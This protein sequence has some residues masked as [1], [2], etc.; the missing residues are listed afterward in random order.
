[1]GMFKPLLK[2]PLL[3]L[4]LMSSFLYGGDE[5]ESVKSAI[6]AVKTQ[7]FYV[8]TLGVLVAGSLS[9]EDVA[10]LQAIQT[11]VPRQMRIFVTQ[12]DFIKDVY[13]DFTFLAKDKQ[14]NAI[15]IWPNSGAADPEFQSKIC[16][17]SKRMKVP[18]IGLQNGWLENGA[19]L[20]VDAGTSPPS[21]L[22]NQRVCE[23]M[24]YTANE[25]N[26]Y[27]TIKQ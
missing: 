25:I 16:M 17:M 12:N 10:A 6:I 4:I 9:S 11:A 21:V 14:V 5:L 18:V 8:Q 7:N 20:Q 22:V 2:I 13:R 15:L 24:N 27:A 1:M 26:G 23:I 19:I 3:L